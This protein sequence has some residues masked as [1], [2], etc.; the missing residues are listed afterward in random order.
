MAIWVI[1]AATIS[2]DMNTSDRL[3]FSHFWVEVAEGGA[4]QVQ[5]QRLHSARAFTLEFLIRGGRCR[6]LEYVALIVPSD[7]TARIQE[8]HIFISHVLCEVIGRDLEFA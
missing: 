6:N 5:A 4:W 7:T 1:S 3:P 2:Q 8:M